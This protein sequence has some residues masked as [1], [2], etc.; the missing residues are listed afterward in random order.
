M[1][2]AQLGHIGEDAFL[3]WLDATE[4][5]DERARHAARADEFLT[6]SLTRRGIDE[7]LDAVSA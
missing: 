4:P 7:M 6:L 2:I 3:R 5:A 1:L